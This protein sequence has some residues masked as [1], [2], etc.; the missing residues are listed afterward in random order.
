[1]STTSW[2]DADAEAARALDI[3]PLAFGPPPEDGAADMRIRAS[4]WDFG[5]QPAYSA[6]QQQYLVDGALYNGIKAV[7]QD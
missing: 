1:M 6:G 3:W 4:V 2:A 5:G 7:K